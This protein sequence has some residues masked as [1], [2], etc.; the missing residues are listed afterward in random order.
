MR[1][2]LT[3]FDFIM[4]IKRRIRDFSG[5]AL[6]SMSILFALSCFSYSPTDASFNVASS[7]PLKNMTQGVGAIISDIALQAFGV[8]AFLA[9]FIL[10]VWGVQLIRSPTFRFNF[11]KLFASLI[12]CVG[13]CFVLSSFSWMNVISNRVDI[14][15]N[16]PHTSGFVGYLLLSHLIGLLAHYK[17]TVLL[18]PILVS[19]FF[20][21]F[22]LV[23]VSLGLTLQQ[24]TFVIVALYRLLTILIVAIG[25]LMFLTYE[26][27]TAKQNLSK[28]HKDDQAFNKDVGAFSQ[29][30]I[31]FAQFETLEEE[32]TIDWHSKPSLSETEQ[33]DFDNELPSYPSFTAPGHVQTNAKAASKGK[34]VTAKKTPA[35]DATH[36]LQSGEYVLPPIDLLEKTLVQRGPVLTE[37]VL[38][39]QAQTL[40]TVLNEF[41][42]DGEIVNIRPGPVVTLFEL[43]PAPGIKSS[44]VIGLADDIARSMSALSAR[45]AVVQGQNVIGIELP[46]K[47]RQTVYLRQLV[48]SNDYKVSQAALPLI[49]GQD[50][51]GTPIVADLA[52]MPHLL[53]AGTTGSGKSVSVNAMILSLLYRLTPQ[54]CKFIMID[55]KMLELSVYDD[56]PHLLTPVVTDPKK[57]VVALKWAV[58]EMEN[59]YRAMSK[60][61][62]RGIDGFNKRLQEARLNG[63]VLMRR[64]QTGFDSETGK[65]I[66][67]NQGLDFEPLP[68]IVVVVDE[69]ADLMLVAGKEIE[70]AIQRLA[71]M[72]RA[73]GIHLIMATQRPSVDVITGTIKA[74]FPTRISFQVTSKIDSRTI[75][76]EQGAEQLLGQGDMLFMPGVGRMSRVHGPFVKDDE[77]E[78]IVG[79]LKMQ[80]E[81]S[82]IDGVTDEEDEM[83]NMDS[84]SQE[85][86]EDAT[87][88]AALEL[89]LREGKASTSFVQR[90]LQ[91]GYNRAAR[92]IE[93]LE[94]N[95]IISAP[96]HVG[97]REIL[98]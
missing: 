39:E 38:K 75:L 78:K 91:I 66:F 43:K 85:S 7:L 81:P 29:A 17:C 19:T 15:S 44:R 63:E 32:P 36:L 31:Q 97:K 20:I 77:V 88:Q 46:N 49:L 95:G 62:V 94:K 24:L 41:G 18:I 65:P 23:W 69:M 33:D 58:K 83:K 45:I 98:T 4:F 64:V 52:K 1:T 3:S 11:F 5:L 37:D 25:Q 82:Y 53:V 13:L 68:Y 86:K 30:H 21:S 12:G 55:P 56:I 57:A 89:I 35:F 72:A 74:N 16:L 10:G 8:V 73:A 76:G 80:G 40:E 90:H 28:T 59:R 70:A 54:H 6:L 79:F 96:N 22:L 2:Q 51:G 50:I 60:L 48:A 93:Q 34:A 92:I 27:L 84:N 9:I 42:I 71:Q 87:Y 14:F 47:T 61:G 67:E 26:K